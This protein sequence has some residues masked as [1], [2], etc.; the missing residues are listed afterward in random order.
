MLCV[1]RISFKF[2]SVSIFLWEEIQKQPLW[3]SGN[4]QFEAHPSPRRWWEQQGCWETHSSVTI[5]TQPASHTLLGKILNGLCVFTF[6][7]SSKRDLVFLSFLKSF[8]PES[9]ATLLK[10]LF[11]LLKY[12]PHSA[13]TVHSLHP[14]VHHHWQGGAWFWH[15]DWRWAFVL[16]LNISTQLHPS[17]FA[18]ICN[19]HPM[20]NL[21]SS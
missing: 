17:C 14:F 7:F 10:C 4:P 20:L 2:S 21:M 19:I 16:V 8:Y 5:K 3:H 6:F 1:S 15:R 9:I 12:L 18:F 13:I 11:P